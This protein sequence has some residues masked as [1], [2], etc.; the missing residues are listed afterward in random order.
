[1]KNVLI[2]GGSGFIG[3]NLTNSLACKY[4]LRLANRGTNRNYSDIII[5]RNNKENCTNLKNGLKYDCIIDLSCYCLDQFKNTYEYLD[6]NKYIFI[7][8]TAVNG[9]PFYNISPDQY[10][11]A[12]YA[13][14]KF[15]CE[16]FIKQNISNHIIIRPCYI[17]G[18]HDNTNR[19]F[20][21]MG[22]WYWQ[23]NKQPLE[24]YMDIE[25]VCDIIEKQIETNYI[26]IIR[27]C[28]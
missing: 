15:Q 26:G 25:H 16:E 20:S 21:F 1:M 18:K 24:Y 19:F 6:F 12:E 4:N 17:V 11:M 22:K 10:E 14:N 8:S 27:P 2:L 3:K 9:Y 13:K 23:S 28:D 7:S 5:N